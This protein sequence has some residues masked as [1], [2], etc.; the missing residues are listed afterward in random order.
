M[1]G[2]APLPCRTR[3]TAQVS[4]AGS[5]AART[6]RPAPQNIQLSETHMAKT[7]DVLIMGATYGSLLAIKLSLAGHNCS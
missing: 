3:A 6:A 7:Y 4:R 5:E 1:P 2:A